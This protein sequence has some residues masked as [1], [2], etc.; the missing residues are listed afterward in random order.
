MAWKHEGKKGGEEMAWKEPKTDWTADDRFNIQDYNRIKNNLEYLHARACMNWGK[1]E[2][3][4]MSGKLNISTHSRAM[5][6]K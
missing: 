3:E 1:F 2:I 4:D 6:T 5:L